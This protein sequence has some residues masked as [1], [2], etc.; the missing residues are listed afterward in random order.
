MR[1][2]IKNKQYFI[3]YIAEDEAR[4][5][6][7]QTK[8][9]NNEVRSDRILPVKRM[10]HFL[11]HN[12]LIAKYSMGNDVGDLASDF[13]ETIFLLPE[14][15][16][17]ESYSLK[18]SIVSIS[19]L[20]DISRKSSEI[21]LGLMRKTKTDWLLDY[22]LH[23]FDR[24]IIISENLLFPSYKSLYNAANEKTEDAVSLIKNYLESKWYKGH[25]NCDWYDS[26]KSKEKIYSGYWSFESG[27]IVKILGLNDAILKDVPYY[28]YDMVHYKK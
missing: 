16:E 14:I 25:I 17:V 1:D 3:D 9:D 10:I 12:L 18:L 8:L 19:I 24:K 26:H 23:Y 15:W 28:P 22:L 20:L 2:K 6:N 5:H 4:I 7:F 27:A 11:K 21:L 13:E